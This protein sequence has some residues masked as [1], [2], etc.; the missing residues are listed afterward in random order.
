MRRPIV[1]AMIAA[2]MLI[3]LA[4]VALLLQ[5]AARPQPAAL[6]ATA[7]L[8]QAQALVPKPPLPQAP[9]GA[10]MLQAKTAELHF[11]HLAIGG[12][13][14]PVIAAKVPQIAPNSPAAAQWQAQVDS[15]QTA[16]Q[17]AL[18]QEI[19]Q[20]IAAQAKQAQAQSNADFITGVVIPLMAALTG[21]MTALAG[22]I[23]AIRPRAGASKAA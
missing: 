12:A 3:G 15:E 17:Q 13:A 20:I 1:F 9:P 21:F 16:Y 23:S 2:G 8:A 22:L 4:G 10:V 11:G 7:V 18:Q 19:N 6:S 14:P 5:H